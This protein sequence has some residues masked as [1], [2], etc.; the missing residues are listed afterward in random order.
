MHGF[1]RNELKVESSEGRRGTEGREGR[2]G[3]PGQRVI[4]LNNPCRKAQKVSDTMLRART[5]SYS[6]RLFGTYSYVLG[7]SS[8]FIQE[9]V[10]PSIVS[11]SVE[12][13]LVRH[14]DGT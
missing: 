9:R 12:R 6:A 1:K 11:K 4:S 3:V 2:R 5:A 8:R 7:L 10:S 14:W 13:P